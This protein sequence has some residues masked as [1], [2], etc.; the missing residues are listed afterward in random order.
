MQGTMPMARLVLRIASQN[1]ATVSVG[2]THFVL[3]N[4][5]AIVRKIKLAMTKVSVSARQNV[6]TVSVGQT[7]FVLTNRVA[8]VRTLKPATMMDNVSA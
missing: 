6:A 3:T 8:I 7:H 5:V 4:H 1:V 2:Q